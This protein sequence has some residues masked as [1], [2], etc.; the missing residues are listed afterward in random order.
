MKALSLFNENFIVSEKLLQQYQL[1]SGLKVSDLPEDQRRSLCSFLGKPFNS[2]FRV[3]SND[4]I[5]LLAHSNFRL[6]DFERNGTL[7]RH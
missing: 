1:A 7:K 2:H 4:R 6:P 3:A 5:T